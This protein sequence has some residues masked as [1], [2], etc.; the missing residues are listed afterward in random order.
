M[1]KQDVYPYIHYLKAS[2]GAG[3]T[4]QLTIRFLS[5]LAGM[6]PS[7]E[8]LRQIVAITFTNRAA[9]EM[10]ER[11]ILALKQIALGEVEGAR[12]THEVGLRPSE[13]TAWLDTILA[14][15]SDFHVRTIDSLVYVLLRA[16]SLEMGLR[17]ELEGVFEQDAVLD[18]CFDRLLARVRWEEAEDR[19]CL[20]FIELLETY[21][22]IEEARG[23][24]VERG[25]RKRLWALYKKADIPSLAGPA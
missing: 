12:L 17:P 14:H 22:R 24:V 7:A 3:K 19:L 15:F 11:I 6:K 13:A 23:L 1:L 18:L 21:L 25:I 4:Y 9:S 2:A 16:F 5:L 8:V 10:K 20:L